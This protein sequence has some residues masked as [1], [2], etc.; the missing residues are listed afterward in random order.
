MYIVHVNS[1]VCNTYWLIVEVDQRTVKNNVSN[2][3]NITEGA[4]PPPTPLEGGS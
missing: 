2:L 1:Y 3:I 4:R